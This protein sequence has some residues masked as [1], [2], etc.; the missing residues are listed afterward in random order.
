MPVPLVAVAG[1]AGKLVGVV[2]GAVKSIGGAIGIHGSSPRY[3]GG[4]LVSTVNQ[5]IARIMSGDLQTIRDWDTARKTAK[6]KSAWQQVWT[7]ELP[8]IGLTAQQ[9]A[10]VR[11]LDPNLAGTPAAALATQA[12]TPSSQPTATEAAGGLFSGTLGSV[13]LAL[14]IAAAIYFVKKRWS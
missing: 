2:E 9:S 8:K 3:A 11:S 12:S 4:P 5:G 10:L 6:D 14:L 7:V 1:E 13:L